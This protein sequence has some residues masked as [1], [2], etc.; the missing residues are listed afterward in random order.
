MVY[1]LSNCYVCYVISTYCM[2]SEFLEGYINY[3]LNL[4]KNY[5]L[6][7]DLRVRVD[8]EALFIA[9]L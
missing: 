7:F 9:N 1:A 2:F 6:Q 3:N 5:H 8:N 4:Q